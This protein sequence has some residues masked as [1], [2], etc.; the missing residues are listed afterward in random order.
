M[1]GVEDEDVEEEDST[2]IYQHMDVSHQQ[3]EETKQGG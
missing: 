3:Q 1:D 2:K